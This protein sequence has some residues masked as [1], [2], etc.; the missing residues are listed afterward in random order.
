[1]VLGDNI[2]FGHGLSEILATADVKASGAT[3]FGYH[4]SDPERYGVISFESDGTVQSIIE[5]PDVPCSN[6]A[7]V[8]V[9][10]C[11]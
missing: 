4:V 11:G 5:K 10:L 7:V 8:G 2:F 6:Y 1:M 3:V 9:I